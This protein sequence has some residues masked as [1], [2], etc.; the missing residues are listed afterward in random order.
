MDVPPPDPADLKPPPRPSY[1]EL[2]QRVQQLDAE[3]QQTN[4]VVQAL[5]VRIEVECQRMLDRNDAQEALLRAR[6]ARITELEALL[7]EH[8]RVHYFEDSD[9]ES[10]EED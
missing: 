1:A 8:N 7:A 3:V 4:G 2:V 5:N 9:E 6:N 10:D